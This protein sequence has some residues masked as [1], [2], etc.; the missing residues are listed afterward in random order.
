MSP[1]GK[2]LHT[3]IEINKYFDENP[4][5]KCDQSVTNTHVPAEWL[6]QAKIDENKNTEKKAKQ[7]VEDFDENKE[8]KV[9]GNM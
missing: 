9:F 6:K 1:D 4:D 2:K 8:K 7:E 3:A 5:V